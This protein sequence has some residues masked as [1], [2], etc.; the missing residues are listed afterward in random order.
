MNEVVEGGDH[1]E[2][3]ASAVVVEST[4]VDQKLD[5]SGY[6]GDDDGYDDEED[7]YDYEV[8]EDDFAFFQS[9]A[10]SDVSS[11][12]K[13][14]DDGTT[15][16]EPTLEAVKMS[17]R[18]ETETTGSKRRL[19]KDLYRIMNQDTSK[20]GYSVVVTG[21]NENNDDDDDSDDDGRDDGDQMM[22]K[23]SIRL[24]KFDEDS[25]LAKDMEVLGIDHIDL[26]MT[27]PDQYPFEPPF[28]QIVRPRFKK[29]TGF[30][31][32]GALC[33]ELLT[34]DGWN[35]IND[36]ESVI[37]CKYES[38][39]IRMLLV[40]Y[41]SRSQIDSRISFLAFSTNPFIQPF[42]RSSWL[43]MDDFKPQLL[44]LRTCTTRCCR[45][46]ELPARKTRTMTTKKKAKTKKMTPSP[47]PYLLVVTNTVPLRQSPPTSIYPIITRR[48]VGLVGGYRTDKND[49]RLCEPCGRLRL[50]M[51]SQANVCQG[52]TQYQ[53][54]FPR[55][56][57]SFLSSMAWP[58]EGIQFAR[59]QRK[60]RN[61]GIV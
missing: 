9:L 21:G 28:C 8:D 2:E 6:Y 40:V 22:N 26:E 17:L 57:K 3:V 60:T 36:I 19:A 44:C 49:E 24:F 51:T 56:K 50:L 61:S 43:G 41:L 12:Q 38:T 32:D 31:I 14:H 53:S 4:K 33:M 54:S 34:A 52:S 35:P 18:A 48:M 59:T 58:V 20:S 47:R 42:V 1:N 13:K 16:K 29:G 11:S 55:K 5:L 15:W 37:V 10:I 23:W 45:K 30:V 25:D 39:M 46:E 27:F 7:E